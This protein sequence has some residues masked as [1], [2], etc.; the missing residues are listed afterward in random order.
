MTGSYGHYENA[1][2]QSIG[3]ERHAYGLHDE[4]G[5]VL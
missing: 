4:R 2:S 1:H 3:Y 5:T